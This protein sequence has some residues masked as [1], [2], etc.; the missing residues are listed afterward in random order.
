ME[1]VE[2][3]LVLLAQLSVPVLVE[4]FG[5]AGSVLI[6]VLHFVTGGGLPPE[7][8]LP[9]PLFVSI[10]SSSSNSW[11]TCAGVRL[12]TSVIPVIN[13]MMRRHVF[14]I[15]EKVSLY[16]IQYIMKYNKFSPSPVKNLLS[17]GPF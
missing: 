15:F 5:G 11:E 4:I 6:P 14:I 10:G 7:S 13:S 17:L 9:P 12:S 8:P 3:N 1:A 16:S 2:R